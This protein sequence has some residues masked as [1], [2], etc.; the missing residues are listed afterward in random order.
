MCST[1]KLLRV[2]VLIALPLYCFAGKSCVRRA[3]LRVKIMSG[4]SGRPPVPP[5]SSAERL[6]SPVSS[7]FMITCFA[8]LDFGIVCGWGGGIHVLGLKGILRSWVQLARIGNS[9]PFSVIFLNVCVYLD[10]KRWLMSSGLPKRASHLHNWDL[11][12]KFSSRFWMPTCRR[13]G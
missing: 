4:P 6:I 11:T 8:S 13:S 12:C 2:L 7:G 5:N 3:T 1:M 9:R 10:G